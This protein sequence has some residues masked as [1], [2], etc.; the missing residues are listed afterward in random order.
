MTAANGNGTAPQNPPWWIHRLE[1][2]QTFDRNATIVLIGARGGGKST[3]AVIAAMS[4]KRKF[5]DIIATFESLAGMRI[6]AFRAKFGEDRAKEREAQLLR[7]VLSRQP[8]NCVVAC[9]S[10]VVDEPCMQVLKEFSDRV[11]I[12]HVTRD[13][14]ELNDYVK[15]HEDHD[16]I[17]KQA[18]ERMPLYRA[19]SDVE[20]RN[21][22]MTDRHNATSEELQSSLKYLERDFLQ[23]LRRLYGHYSEIDLTINKKYTHSLLL[24]FFDLAQANLDLDEA[25]TGIDAIELRIDMIVLHAMQQDRDPLEQ[26]SQ[27]VAFAR[28]SCDMPII[29]NM[30]KSFFQKCPRASPSD[31]YIEM[32]FYGLSLQVDYLTVC[33]DLLPEKVIRAIVERKGITK[34]I[35]CT[36]TSNWDS[37]RCAGVINTMLDLGC[38]LVKLTSY[39]LTIK[40]NFALLA[41]LQ[42]L[43]S[44][45]R[46]RV[47]AYNEGLL[48]KMSRCLNPTLSPVDDAMLHVPGSF[49]RPSTPEE[50]SLCGEFLSY[51]TEVQLTVRESLIS[52]YSMFLQPKLKFYHVGG[53]VERRVSHIAYRE[54]LKHIGIP[55]EYLV[56]KIDHVSEISELLQQP[57]FGGLAVSRPFKSEIIGMLH[58]VSTNARVIGACNSVLAIRNPDTFLPVSLYG[59]NTDWIGIQRMILRNLSTKHSITSFSAAVVLGAGGTG[60]SA[61]YALIQLGVRNIYV[62]DRDVA[63]TKEVI[64]HF[65]NAFSHLS[66]PGLTAG[67]VASNAVTSMRFK[68]SARTSYG[69]MSFENQSSTPLNMSVLDDYASQWPSDKVLP[70]III[71]GT[72]MRDFT[73][74]PSMLASGGLAVDVVYQ[75]DPTALSQQLSAIPNWKIMDGREL[76]TE[77]AY[78]HFEL[79]MGKRVSRRFV[80]DTVLRA[81]G[82]L[83]TTNC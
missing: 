70:S 79:M 17:L 33:T 68:K 36:S 82:D 5:V 47:I 34:V 29:Y 81:I 46:R 72:P 73:V 28:R 15:D 49:Y 56:K 77:Q 69:S 78:V 59:E 65:N 27:Q 66:V 40:D 48:G 54:G 71:N 3:L 61:I 4:L 53:E 6:E 44:K 19:V 24:P 55:H 42:G 31:T 50:Q 8:R 30:S 32:L 20:F 80:K 63:K 57:D 26:V 41:A 18:V 25:T 64:V 51:N 16:L 7:E 67:D 35:G 22:G 52:I 10:G 75:N 23:L 58:A 83:N 39:A 37:V 13:L 2:G 45:L 11:L 38:D 9:S 62:Y 14:A 60:R 21:M 74:H 12:L 43:D 76:V 1:R